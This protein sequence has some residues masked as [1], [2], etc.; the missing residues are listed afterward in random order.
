LGPG[1]SKKDWDLL[2][3]LDVG[4]SVVIL[5]DL[6][7]RCLRQGQAKC[8]VNAENSFLQFLLI[9]KPDDG[10][11]LAF[12]VLES[13]PSPVRLESL[14]IRKPLCDILGFLRSFRLVKTGE[15]V[16]RKPRLD[17]LLGESKR[18]T[19]LRDEPW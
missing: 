14:K 2:S 4:P 11:A 13:N 19:A 5:D 7:R 6:C 1:R 16:T 3:H 18:V 8:V 15:H 10:E 9:L 17:Q 12:S